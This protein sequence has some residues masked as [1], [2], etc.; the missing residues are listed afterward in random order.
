MGQMLSR[1]IR[2]LEI[3]ERYLRPIG[4]HAGTDQAVDLKKLKRLILERK[5]APCYEGLEEDSDNEV[6]LVAES[7]C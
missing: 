7:I 2:D 3:D 6:C 5:L 4:L 1:G